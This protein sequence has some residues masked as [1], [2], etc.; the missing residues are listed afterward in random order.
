MEFPLQGR[1]PG[2]LLAEL[3]ARKSGDVPW[4]DGRTFAYVYDA[5]PEAM[6]LLKD[7]Y[8]MYLVENGLDPTSF[9]SCRDLE[10]DIIGMAIDLMRGG[11]A[12]RG[13][14]TSGGTESILLSVKAARDWARVERPAVTMPQLLLPETAHPAFFKACAYFDVQPVVV[15]VVP[16]RF[17]ADPAAMEQAITGRTIMMVGSAP[18]YAHGVVDPIPELAAVAQ[19]HGLLLHVDC[20]VGGMY[21]PWVR[22]LGAPLP[23][24]DFGVPGVTQLSMDFHKWGYAAKGASAV[25]YRDERVWQHQIFAWSGWTGYTVVNP[26]IQSTKSGGPLAAC[27]ATLQYFGAD[28][29]LRLVRSTQDAARKL[30]DAVAGIDGVYVLGDPPG[31]LLALAAR[32]F[33]IFGLA[34]LMRRRGWYIQPQFGSGNSPANVHFSIGASNVPQMDALIADLRE[35]V[36]QLRDGRAGETVAAQRLAPEAIDALASAAPGEIFERLGRLAGATDGELPTDMRAVNN[37][38][39]ALPA[40]LRDGLLVEFVKRLYVPG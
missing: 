28:G 38:L 26:T 31:N 17:V 5:G 16:G 39:N 1:A 8:S 12:A 9:P 21:L 4:T 36:A 24:F 34:D 25:L 29:Y 40:K 11:S 37:L 10:R 2:E 30:R 3:A 27:W 33:D 14:F 6:Q 20:C 18:S 23:E 13:S 22:R 32:D 15:P 7:A 19:R 35:C